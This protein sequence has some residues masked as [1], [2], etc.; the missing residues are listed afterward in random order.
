M[1][2]LGERLKD[3]Q[4][5]V[6]EGRS[7]D[8]TD[9]MKYLL[10]YAHLASLIYNGWD[11]GNLTP[12]ELA[13]PSLYRAAFRAH[14]RVAKKA[15]DAIVRAV[16]AG[17]AGP[18]ADALKAMAEI[19]NP[20]NFN[21]DD[22]DDGTFM[23]L[24]LRARCTLGAAIEKINSVA[25]DLRIA[26]SALSI[27]DASNRQNYV[28]IPWRAGVMRSLMEK[29]APEMREADQALRDNWVAV[30]DRMADALAAFEP[31]MIALYARAMEDYVERGPGGYGYR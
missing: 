22:M 11:M 19:G 18:P 5:Q 9:R 2:T 20:D 28:D 1:D 30:A 15:R 16:R 23:V 12:P 6:T 24:A 7:A 3:A 26:M 8:A 4:R 17:E 14:P 21:M 10:G 31:L 25:N 13:G 27:L 29:W